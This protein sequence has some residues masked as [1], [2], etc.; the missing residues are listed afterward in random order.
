MYQLYNDFYNDH[1][2][3]LKEQERKL[4]MGRKLSEYEAQ[5]NRNNSFYLFMVMLAFRNLFH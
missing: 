1:Q 5:Q 2:I 3:R 4:E